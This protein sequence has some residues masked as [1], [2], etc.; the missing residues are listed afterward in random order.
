M[1]AP[2]S[3]KYGTP[4]EITTPA[5]SSIVKAGL[6]RLGA[7]THSVDMDQRYIPLSLTSGSGTLTAV[8]PTNANVA[9]PG[10]Y[11]LFIV[12]A[13]GV[14]SVAR[15]VTV[16]DDG[17]ASLAASASDADAPPPAPPPAAPPP[18]PPDTTGPVLSALSLSPSRFAAARKGAS[19][20][21][22]G[23]SRVSYKLS[24]PA[25]VTLSVQ[26]ASAGRRAGGRCVKPK[27]S[28]RRAKRCTRYRTLTGRFKHR[29]TTGKNT[30]RFSGRLR[31]RKL[32]PGHYR[33][34]AIA[35]DAAANNSRPNAAAFRSCAAEF[36]RFFATSSRVAAS[37]RRRRPRPRPSARLTRHGLRPSDRR[38]RPNPP[39]AVATVNRTQT[40]DHAV[41]SPPGRTT[42]HRIVTVARS[43]PAHSEACDACTPRSRN[44][45]TP[46][47]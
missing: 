1:A 7:V 42:P 46:T 23:R 9:P 34:N 32:A 4:F 6:V 33:L 25:T 29:G 37:R 31:N 19:I 38:P 22:Q 41:I 44:D 2:A 13:A 47:E 10:P 28:N 5:A 15:M 20:I 27:R 36:V 12:N 17:A 16:S 35:T 8:G 11:M 30:F 26:R 40:I 45:T 18:A 39:N 43:E 14:P 21:T 3:I 24:E